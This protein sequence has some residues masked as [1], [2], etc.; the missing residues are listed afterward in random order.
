MSETSLM[1]GKYSHFMN[2]VSKQWARRKE[3]IKGSTAKFTVLSEYDRC[4]L[5]V[6]II[7]DSVSDYAC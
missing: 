1:W 7:D 2:E 4:R 5:I 6:L 3:E